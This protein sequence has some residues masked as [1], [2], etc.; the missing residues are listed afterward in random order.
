MQKKPQFKVITQISDFSRFQINGDVTKHY[1]EK[2][3]RLKKYLPYLTAEP[4]NG[5]IVDRENNFGLEVHILLASEIVVIYSMNT[6]KLITVINPQCYQ[7]TR[8]FKGLNKAMQPA[9]Y[10]AMESAVYRNDNYGWKEDNRY[11]KN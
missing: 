10:I 11:G 8:Y 6:A 2:E 3:E 7:V 5:F 4:I 9:D 1:V